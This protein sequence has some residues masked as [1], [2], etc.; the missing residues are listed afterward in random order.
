MDGRFQ[1]SQEFRRIVDS[2][3][4]TECRPGRNRALLRQYQRAAADRTKS[5]TTGAGSTADPRYRR[6]L[7]LLRA[8]LC[9]ASGCV[10]RVLGLEVL[11]QLLASDH[12]D[13]ECQHRRK[14]CNTT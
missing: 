5:A 6:I 8:D 7:A 1:R 10:R 4:L 2:A 3:E 9:R 13:P 11:L 14:R 12:R